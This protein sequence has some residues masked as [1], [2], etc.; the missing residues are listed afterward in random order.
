ML[1]RSAIHR[2]LWIADDEQATGTRRQRAPVAVSGPLRGDV[3]HD[4]RLQRVG[5]L[6]L[7]DEHA[8]KA[9]LEIAANLGLVAQEVARPDQE[10]VVVGLAPRPSLVLV[11]AHELLDQ[12]QDTGER[13][14]PQR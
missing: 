12:R 1:F 4:L 2:L 7:I 8:R 3:H 14:K 9:L 5:V 6:E 13:V 11:R 10:V